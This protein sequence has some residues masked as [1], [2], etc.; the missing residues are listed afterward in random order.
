M[1]PS[2][3]RRHVHPRPKTSTRA[4]LVLARTRL[5][6]GKEKERFLT[7]RVIRWRQLTQAAEARRFRVALSFPG[8]HRARVEKIAEELVAK[9]GWEK[10]LYDGWYAEEF[11]R[12]NVDTYLTRLYHDK[13]DLYSIDGYLDIRN[14]ADGD[15]AVAILSRIGGDRPGGLSYRVPREFISVDALP[16]NAMG[17]IQ[18]HLLPRQ[19]QGE[20]R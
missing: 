20:T 5:S 12:V 8:E 13:S 14:M 3:G 19:P 4:G 17:K 1:A 9:L 15:V 16:R 7:K 2:G 10:V 11:A 6:G 18:K